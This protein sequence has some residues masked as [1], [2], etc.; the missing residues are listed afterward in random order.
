MIDLQI[1]WRGIVHDASGYSRYA[2]DQVLALDAE[3]VDVRLEPLNF[4]TPAAPLDPR[5]AD[6]LRRLAEKPVASDKLRVL[7]VNMLPTVCNPLAERSRYDVVICLT[8]YEATRVPLHWMLVLNSYD[9]VIVCSKQCV[10]SFEASGV[11]V[12]VHLVPVGAP[13]DQFMPGTEKLRIPGAEAHFKFLS[14][15]QWNHRKGPDILLRAFWSEF[16]A[17]DKVALII[18]SCAGSSGRIL[19]QLALRQQIVATKRQ[20]GFSDDRAPVLLNSAV[21]P[22]SAMQLLYRAAD[23]FVLPTRGEGAGLPFVESM[24]SGT[25]VIAT[26]WGGQMDFL[27]RDN[28]WIIDYDLTSTT[29]SQASPIGPIFS[30]LLEEGM[31]WAECK[32]SA[33][34]AAMRRAHDNPG[35]LR[36]KGVNARASMEA[37]PWT[38]SAHALT[39]AVRGVCDQSARSRVQPATQR[40]R[41]PSAA[42]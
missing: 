13:V 28:A 18:K 42:L 9:A 26:G 4:G 34:Q 40:G 41:A 37:M 5:Q 25:P 10:A 31:E 20:L 17:R 29:D 21:L 24:C 36:A 3:G 30:G 27:N 1:N 8:M 12:P 14:V 6:R 23:V 35:E 11:K 22:D 19:D 7:I 33:L 32:L 38:R 2:R 15:F 39:N 16:S